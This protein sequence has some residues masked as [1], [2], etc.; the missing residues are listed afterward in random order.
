MIV[1]NDII[2]ETLVVDNNS[3]DNTKKVISDFIEVGHK[4]FHYLFEPNQG[5]CYAL[6][7][8][9]RAAK[10]SIIAFTDDDAIV[11]G[12]WLKAIVDTVKK[13]DVECVGGKVLPIWEGARPTWL[14]DD[15]LNVLAI[16]DYGDDSFEFERRNNNR[17]LFGV[18]VAFK[19]EFFAKE[20]SFKVE[21]GSRGEDQEIFERLLAANGRAIYNPEIVVHHK[22]NPQ[23][24]TKSYYRKWYFESG[25]ARAK[26]NAASRISLLGIPGYTIRQS[27]RRLKAFLYS[28]ITLNK[29]AF[30]SNELWLIFYYAFFLDKVK[31]ALLRAKQT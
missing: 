13:S 10:G 2:W 12:H 18:N 11:D 30:F 1:P 23:R 24:L 21:L 16:L 25:K 3:T 22:I 14:S 28:A 31:Y 4:R 6:N 7:R 27:V 17:M 8:G 26:L 19:K 29:S 9:I 5:K 20:G 15:L